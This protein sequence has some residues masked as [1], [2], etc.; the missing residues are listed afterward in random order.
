MGKR[1]RQTAANRQAQSRA[2]RRTADLA[3]REALGIP[4]G[5]KLPQ[6]LG[7]GTPAGGTGVY[8]GRDLKAKPQGWRGRYTPDVKVTSEQVRAVSCPRCL[9]K[10]ATPC[11]NQAG[12]A[13]S[14]GHAARR[15]LAQRT[16]VKRLGRQRGAAEPALSR[17]EHEQLV[18]RQERHR[19]Q[20]APQVDHATG[21]RVVSAAAAVT[22]DYTARRP[23]TTST[24]RTK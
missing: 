14:A 22:R 9:A 3:Y 17:E 5:T 11:R 16:E 1:S 10:P 7:T 23:K 8:R 18:A 2:D 20:R 19:Q 13:V 21:K 24:P 15:A 4:A 6:Q 12:A